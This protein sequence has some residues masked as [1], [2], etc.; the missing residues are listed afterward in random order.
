[1]KSQEHQAM[2]HLKSIEKQVMVK[3]QIFSDAVSLRTLF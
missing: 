3:N 2:Q 1:M